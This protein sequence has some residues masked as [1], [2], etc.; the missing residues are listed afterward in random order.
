[1]RTFLV[2]LKLTAKKDLLQDLTREI[3]R[4]CKKMKRF[5]R[6]DALK[7]AWCPRFQAPSIRKESDRKNQEKRE[8]KIALKAL[9]TELQKS[10]RRKAVRTEEKS[11]KTE[12][13]EM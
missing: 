11:K 13:S 9:K 10:H 5:L 6:L 2:C 12:K 3:E 8:G 7:S 4:S 1:V